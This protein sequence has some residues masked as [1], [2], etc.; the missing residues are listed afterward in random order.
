MDQFHKLKR[1]DGQKISDNFRPLQHLG[2]RKVIF[3]DNSIQ[4]SET[5][6][7]IPS[8][9]YSEP[10]ITTKS[11]PQSNWGPKLEV[12][13]EMSMTTKDFVFHPSKLNYSAFF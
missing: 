9:D 8:E 4:T 11:I 1:K 10:P 12:T 7:S 5:V 6:N 13:T 3:T 2:H